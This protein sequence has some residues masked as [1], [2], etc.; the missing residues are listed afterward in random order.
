MSA[1]DPKRRAGVFAM[2][3]ELVTHVQDQAPRIATLLRGRGRAAARGFAE[4]RA[5]GFCIEDMS[6][7]TRLRFRRPRRRE[8]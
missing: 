4:E 2:L 1:F 7:G 5:S 3:S 8:M 6:N